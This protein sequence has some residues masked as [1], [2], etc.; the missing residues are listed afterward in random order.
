M[1]RRKIEMNVIKGGVITT[2]FDEM[3]PPLVPEYPEPPKP[4]V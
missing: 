1:T 3:R 4:E 2:P